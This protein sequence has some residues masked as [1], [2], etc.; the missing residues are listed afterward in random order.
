MGSPAEASWRNRQVYG[1]PEDEWREL[2]LSVNTRR[3]KRRL[4]PAETARRLHTALQN[5]DASTIAT[6]LGFS[7]TTTMRRIERLTILPADLASL[8]DWGTRRG[9]VSMS[10]ASEL[11]RL[12]DRDAI[13]QAI[14][15]AIEH[16]LSRDEARQV[17]Q[18]RD[19][20]QESLAECIQRVL[21]SRPRIER[22]E[23]V[24]G[25]L[26]TQ[27]ARDAAAR[28]GDTTAARKLGI[29]LARR[30]PE[31]VLRAIRMTGERFS[32]MFNENDAEKLRAALGPKSIEEAVTD[33]V[34]GIQ[35]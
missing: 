18:I 12:D 3:S 26:L 34:E 30:C 32:I 1:L 2:I 33:I 4:S 5:G 11:L 31:I 22:S 15:A 7:D 35:A 17:V 9:R 21:S 16:E 25:S 8:V 23:L 24:I 19:R 14:M 13:R 20:S 10:A 6:A 28:V 27:E 29:T